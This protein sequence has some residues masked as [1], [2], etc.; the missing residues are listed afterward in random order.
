METVLRFSWGSALE[1]VGTFVLGLLYC[2]VFVF[3]LDQWPFSDFFLNLCGTGHQTV[4]SSWPVVRRSLTFGTR[5]WS[6]PSGCSLPLYR[7][8]HERH[9]WF[10]NSQ[11]VGWTSAPRTLEPFPNSNH[12]RPYVAHAQH[13]CS[14]HAGKSLAGQFGSW[15]QQAWDLLSGSQGLSSQ[16]AWWLDHDFFCLNT[17]KV[18]QISDHWPVI[19]GDRWWYDLIWCC[20]SVSWRLLDSRREDTLALAP[21]V[22]WSLRD[23]M[24]EEASV[25]S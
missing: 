8:R 19:D 25:G 23:G 9:G 2:F 21:G 24:C 18:K 1:G 3:F 5:R 4:I 14:Q 20:S 11:F 12:M 16:G 6:L 13:C 15:W 10:L 7:P 22:A 17:C